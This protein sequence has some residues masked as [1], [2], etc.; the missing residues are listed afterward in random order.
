[1]KRMFLYQQR[2]FAKVGKAA[3]SIINAKYILLLL[4]DEVDNTNQLVEACKVYMASD[5]FMTELE[6]LE[7][8]FF[9]LPCYLPISQLH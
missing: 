5:L 2:R 4:L 8:G 7:L 9:Q 6:V 1:M 3:A